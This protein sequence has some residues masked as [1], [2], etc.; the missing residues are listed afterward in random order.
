[1]TGGLAGVVLVSLATRWRTVLTARGLYAQLLARTR[2]GRSVL[3]RRALARVA[4]RRVPQQLPTAIVRRMRVPVAIVHGRG[5]RMVHAGAALE[6]F[7][8]APEPRRLEL[9]DGMSHS[10]QAAAVPAVVRAVEWVLEQ[11]TTAATA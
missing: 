2:P 8:A 9:V 1:V 10:F 6:L 7:E 4:A 11:G 5:D 3:R